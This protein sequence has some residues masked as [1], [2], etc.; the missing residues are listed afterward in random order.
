MNN[1]YTELI[2]F[3]QLHTRKRLIY[4]YIYIYKHI[5][6]KK[7]PFQ[8]QAD[9]IPT[10]IFAGW[11]LV[12][13]LGL[14]F[15]SRLE[16]RQEP[17]S[18]G[19]GFKLKMMNMRHV[20]GDETKPYLGGWTTQIQKNMCQKWPNANFLPQIIFSWPSRRIPCL[21]EVSF[22]VSSHDTPPSFGDWEAL[23]KILF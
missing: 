5:S 18:K 20:W 15:H 9:C 1:T 4:M 14:S 11:A 3:N 16:M 22:L 2:S 21:G 6:L 13:F 10:I 19:N 17:L 7:E 8:K 23:V 12:S